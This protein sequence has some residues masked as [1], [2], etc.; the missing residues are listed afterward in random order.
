[1]VTIEHATDHVP[2]I[3]YKTLA[4][5]ITYGLYIQI[6]YQDTY[7]VQTLSSAWVYVRQPWFGPIEP[8]LVNSAW[9][10]CLLAF[11]VN[12]YRPLGVG[13]A[14]ERASLATAGEH[15]ADEQIVSLEESNIV[16]NYR[17]I[18]LHMDELLLY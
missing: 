12:P 14:D 18:F 17:R 13:A 6:M 8:Y 7:V 11:Q 10:A 3:P 15:R 4:C 16:Y 5:V 9:L 2:Y 1:M